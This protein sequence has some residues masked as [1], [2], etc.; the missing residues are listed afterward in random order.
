MTLAL[1]GGGSLGA[2]SWGVLDRLLDEPVLRIGAASGASAGAMNAAMLAQGLATG[3]PGEAKRLLEAFWRRVASASGSPDVAGAGTLLP[4]AGLMSPV[5]DALRQ[6]A[7]GLSRTQV[8]PLGLNPLRG[9]LDGLLDPS[10]FGTP[11]APTLVISATRV[12]TG[13]AKLFRDAEV[14]AEA[15][16]ASACLPQLFPTVVID[17][18]A[19]WDGG[20]AANPPL[21]ALVEAGAPADIVLV[22]TTPEER[23]DLPA[24]ASG[25]AERV[26]EIA[27]GTALRQELRSLALAQRFLTDVPA[28]AVDALARL[29]DARMHVI[30]A[31]EAFRALKGGSHRDAS[32][33]FLTEMRDLGRGAADRWLAAHRGSVGVRSTM[34]LSGY[35]ASGLVPALGAAPL[36]VT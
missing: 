2:F 34:D 20:Y 26:D 32:W 3:G 24:G 29:R 9:V 31:E 8:N 35:A 1:Q 27:F 16:L 11:N 10:A 22:R 21:R 14:T 28:S 25:V 13:E 5:A 12:R 17:G 36:T 15:L 18:E 30:G 7:R 6:A 23:P 19:Y 33:G 4:F